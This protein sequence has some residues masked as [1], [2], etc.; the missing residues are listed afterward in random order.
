MLNIFSKKT[1]TYELPYLKL[2]KESEKGLM[3]VEESDYK[4]AMEDV[5]N[6]QGTYYLMGFVNSQNVITSQLTKFVVDKDGVYN[7]RT[8]KGERYKWNKK[9]A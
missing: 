1:K 6:K 9:S 5:K 4:K 2:V 3:I 7:A 8:V